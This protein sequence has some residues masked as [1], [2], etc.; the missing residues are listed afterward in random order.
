MKITDY[1]ILFMTIIFSFIV[2]YFLKDSILFQKIIYSEEINRVVDNT[3]VKALNDGYKG[4]IGNDDNID[5]D[6]VIESFLRNM[7]YITY[8]VDSN[9]NRNRIT[10]CIVCLIIIMED[11]YYIYEDGIL[12]KKLSFKNME[13]EKKVMEL[14]DVI[15]KSVHKHNYKIIFPKNNGEN[16][17]Q[18]INSNSLLVIYKTNTADFFGNIYAECIIS[19]ATIKS[20]E[21]E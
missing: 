19:G 6:L 2:I 18:T 15:E 9:Y 8:G 4:F 7:S 17:S 1:A 20:F 11:G 13:H 12:G 21:Y 14:E 3:T 5:V 10:D 16:N